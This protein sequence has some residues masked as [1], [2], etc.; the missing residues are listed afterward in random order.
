MQQTMLKSS[1][2]IERLSESDYCTVCTSDKLLQYTDQYSVTGEIGRFSILL[3]Y[4][5]YNNC[6]ASYF[7]SVKH[8]HGCFPTLILSKHFSQIVI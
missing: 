2:P 8:I 7:T 4:S 3:Y 1:R 5:Y 6:N